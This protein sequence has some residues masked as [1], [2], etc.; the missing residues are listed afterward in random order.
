MAFRLIDVQCSVPKTNQNDE[1]T[2]L[3]LFSNR[4]DDYV[5]ARFELD[6]TYPVRIFANLIMNSSKIDQKQLVFLRSNIPVD[7]GCFIGKGEFEIKFRF[8]P[9]G[10]SKPVAS[11]QFSTDGFGS[12]TTPEIKIFSKQT[13]VS[14]Y[15]TKNR[16]RSMFALN[17]N[18]STRGVF[19]KSAYSEKEWVPQ[20][21]S[22]PH[23]EMGSIRFQ[24]GTP[25]LP[26]EMNP[27][28]QGRPPS[29]LFT[30]IGNMGSR[31]F[32]RKTNGSPTRKRSSV[33]Q[34]ARR[35]FNRYVA[36][37][38]HTADSHPEHSPV[39]RRSR[40]SHLIPSANY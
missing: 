38:L 40:L 7:G 12:V 20:A 31:T 3:V 9:K 27:S 33:L 15:T 32:S 28:R 4:S 39:A 8:K 30:S 34:D 21:D 36:D 18:R 1:T 14:T 17:K 26:T 29:H 19:E 16:D 37:H 24:V 35:H 23:P 2:A 10:V 11:V 5:I 6:S 25:P 13:S 22:E